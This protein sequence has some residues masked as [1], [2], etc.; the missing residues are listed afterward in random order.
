MSEQTLSAPSGNGATASV[1]PVGHY[2]DGAW[3]GSPTTLPSR[4]PATGDVL[5]HYAEGGASEARAAIAA[6]RRAFDATDW[7]RDRDKRARALLQLA[8]LLEARQEQFVHALTRE[9]GKPLAEA[10]FEIALTIPKLRYN[11]ALALTDSGRAAEAQPGLYGMTLREPAGVAGIIVPWNSPIVL[12]VRSLA[13][14]LAAGCTAAVKMPGQTAL[15]NATFFELLAEADALPAGVVNLFNESGNEGAP[16]LVESPDVDVISYTGSTQVGR[17][18]MRQA[19]DWLKPVSLELGGKTPTIVF[20]DA[21]LDAVVPTI[22]KSVT[23]FAGEFC[24]TGSRVLAQRSIADEL[25]ERLRDA[26]S[27]VVAGPGDDPSTDIGPMID[28]ANV[29]RV[30]RIVEDALAYAT[31]IVRGGPITAGPLAAGAYYAPALLETDDPASPIV[32]QEV[33]GPVATFEVFD[34]EADAVRLANA[35]DYGLA[36]GVWTRD[37]ER[38]LRVGREL[39]AGTVWTNAWAVVV[40]QFEEGGFKQSGVGRLNGLRALEEFQQVKTYLHVAAPVG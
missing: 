2:I 32:Q 11:A 20:E 8:D 5:G 28:K 29:E 37:A 34:T 22:V 25:R 6:A 21:D 18:I 3:T 27:A 31:P 12:L 4:N 10:G 14:A 35:T 1:E 39:R 23:T 19:A 17:I 9:N 36:A 30:D 16:L 38:P 24:M 13:P 7:S 15:T 26:L 40:D 33:F